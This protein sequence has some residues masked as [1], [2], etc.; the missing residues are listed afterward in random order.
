MFFWHNYIPYSIILQN[1]YRVNFGAFHFYHL[2]I[3]PKGDS[4]ASLHNMFM[5]RVYDL[6]SL[7][8]TFIHFDFCET[9]PR[10]YDQM[11]VL[12]RYTFRHKTSINNVITLLFHLFKKM[13]HHN[14]FS[15]LI[16]ELPSS[17][18]HINLLFTCVHHIKQ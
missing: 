17:Y 6:P 2:L 10:C 5:V 12:T 8:F 16:R 3:Q 11:T 7:W 13:V 1:C 14:H 9:D 18:N 4:N 15:I